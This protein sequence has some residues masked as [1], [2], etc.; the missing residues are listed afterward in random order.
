MPGHWRLE[1]RLTP[2][3]WGASHLC[4]GDHL[5]GGALGGNTPGDAP[6]PIRTFLRCQRL[7]D[8]LE[9]VVAS[10]GNPRQPD[11]LIEYLFL[12]SSTTASVVVPPN[13]YRGLIT[14]KDAPLSAS[15]TRMG[16]VLKDAINFHL[17]DPAAAY[18]RF[19][20][21]RFNEGESTNKPR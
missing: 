17:P 7:V 1:G 8:V 10:V 20:D 4:A 13:W 19:I 12:D 16:W 5:A 21:R 18:T 6:R 2:S 11:S 3:Q 9:K 14:R 15:Q